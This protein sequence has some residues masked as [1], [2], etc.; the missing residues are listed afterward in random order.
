MTDE[1]LLT[2][3]D[4]VQ[5]G[6]S[7]DEHKG[8]LIRAAIEFD[9]LTVMEILTPRIQVAAVEEGSSLEQ[10]G[11]TFRTHGFFPSARISGHHRH[12]CRRYP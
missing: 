8:E 7:I 12:D 9:D 3:V 6:G 1:E 11:D 10:I 2:I 5:S 4:E